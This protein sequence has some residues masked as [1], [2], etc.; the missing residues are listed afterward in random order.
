MID[1]QLVNTIGFLS[2]SAILIAISKLN[3]IKLPCDKHP[4]STIGF[5]IFFAFFAF[6]AFVIRFITNFF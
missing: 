5:V 4:G 2:F 3:D 1:D 6:F